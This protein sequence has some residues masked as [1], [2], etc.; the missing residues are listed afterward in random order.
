MNI[1]ET[2]IVDV[3]G[4]SFFTFKDSNLR[5]A[6]PKRYYSVVH[7]GFCCKMGVRPMDVLV[8][9]EDSK[10]TSEEIATFE[11]LGD[12][13]RIGIRVGDVLMMLITEDE[14]RYKRGDVIKLEVREEKTHLFDIE[15]GDRIREKEI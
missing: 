3:D 11:N 15:T 2:I 12:E 5:I 4:T 6:V 8:G 1:L 10:G 7:D 13:R 9:G 14:K